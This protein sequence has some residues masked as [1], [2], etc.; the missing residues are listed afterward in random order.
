[1]KEIKFSKLV[2]EKD[3]KVKALGYCCEEVD[4]FLDEVN[5]EIVKLERM[6]QELKEKFDAS[7]TKLK[8]AEQRNKELNVTIT[9]LKAQSTV[10]STSNANFSNID[11]LNRLNN[12]E[13]MLSKLLENK[14]N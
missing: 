12:L 1:M 8:A 2:Y 11:I 5:L 3:F 7:E 13:N 6:Y 14:D 4:N 9:T 10:T